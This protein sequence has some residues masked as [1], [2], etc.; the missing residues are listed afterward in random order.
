MS[1][2]FDF[3][4]CVGMSPRLARVVEIGCNGQDFMKFDMKLFISSILGTVEL[5]L[6]WKSCG[7]S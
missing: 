5:N 7:Q 2:A 1:F 4:N 3:E 6:Y